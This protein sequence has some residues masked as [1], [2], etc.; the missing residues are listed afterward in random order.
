MSSADFVASVAS[1]CDIDLLLDLSHLMI[2]CVNTNVDPFAQIK[3]F[4]L[5]RVVEIHISGSSCKAESCGRPCRARAKG[6]FALLERVLESANPRA[7]TLEYNWSELPESVLLHIPEN[8]QHRLEPMTARQIQAP[9]RP[10]SVVPI[11]S[12]SG[13]AIQ[14][15]CAA[16][17][18]NSINLSALWRFAGL[19][20]KVRHNGI[21]NLLPMQTFRLMKL[22]NFELDPVRTYGS[23]LLLAVVLCREHILHDA[24]GSEFIGQWRKP[25][26]K[27]I[28]A[29]L[30]FDTKA[31]WRS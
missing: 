14:A 28:L 17:G 12:K 25:R 1:Y 23:S 3:R 9:W 16:T 24:K 7:I 6:S 18:S 31:Y 29:A 13:K 26:A 30:G 5:E 4:P 27:A 10:G 21:R 2:T 20:V 8:A 15:S 22:A 19:T 11:S